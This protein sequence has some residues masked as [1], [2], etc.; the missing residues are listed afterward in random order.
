MSR[1]VMALIGIALFVVG[2][3]ITLG[4]ISGVALPGVHASQNHGGLG[5]GNSET[6]L[7][8]VL[9]LAISLAGLIL[10]T[11]GPAISFL[12]ARRQKS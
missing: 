2:F 3:V 6:T 9:G 4:A 12:K 8:M 7:W 5:S 1:S 11:V 10:A